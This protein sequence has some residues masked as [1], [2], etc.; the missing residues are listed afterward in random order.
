MTLQMAAAKAYGMKEY[1]RYDP[2]TVS[3]SPPDA[4][5]SRPPRLIWVA[6]AE[7]PAET[8]CAPEL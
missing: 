6:S 2:L 8:I 4:T 3:M 7:P 5:I 1:A